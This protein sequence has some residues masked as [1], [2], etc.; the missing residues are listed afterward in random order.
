MTIKIGD[1]LPK[2]QLHA[3]GDDGIIETSLYDWG[4][5]KSALLIV[6]PGA[7]TPT[8]SAR[9]LP[10]YIDHAEDFGA[11]GIEALGCMAVNDIHVMSAWSEASGATGKIDMLAD[12]SGEVAEAMGIAVVNVPVLGNTR[13]GRLALVAQDGVIEQ[14]YI[15][16]P[17]AFE[18]SAAE[19]V[20]ARL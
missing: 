20:L 17:A 12:A 11:K 13:A 10:G 18:V 15:E 14:L 1:T 5:G 4:A 16:E 3:K 2:T 7:F 19:Y 8:C 9:H 6:V